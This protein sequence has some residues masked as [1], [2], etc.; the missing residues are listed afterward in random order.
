[1]EYG[2]GDIERLLKE[3]LWALGR[4]AYEIRRRLSKSLSP[5][6]YYRKLFNRRLEVEFAD[7][8]FKQRLRRCL[9]V[10][11]SADLGVG[12]RLCI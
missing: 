12:R 6:G 5:T 2:R 10:S 7:V 11:W 9:G 4:R 1:V 3:D 8:G